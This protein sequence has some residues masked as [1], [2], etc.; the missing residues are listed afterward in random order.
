M[1]FN[2]TNAVVS[3][4]TT[5]QLTVA[6]PTGA[7]SGRVSVTAPSG[8]D[9]SDDDFIVPP[10]T[11]T[12]GQV[13][14]AARLSSPD[15]GLV[16]TVNATNKIA[17]ALFDGA[18]GQRLSL[19]FA[20]VSMSGIWRVYS[21]D[22]S[23]LTWSG[24]ATG[25]DDVDLGPLTQAGTYSLVLVPNNS[26]G[27]A[28]V[29]V[30]SDVL[31]NLQTD[32]TPLP[33]SLAAGQ[34]AMI[35]F[36][37][38]A[39]ETYNFVFTNYVST[40]EF[41]STAVTVLESDGTSL[42]SCGGFGGNFGL[43]LQYAGHRHLSLA[44][45]CRRHRCHVVRG[46]A[47]HRF[48]GNARAGLADR[49][50][51]GQGSAGTLGSSSA[52]ATGQ[53]V[54]RR[55]NLAN[56]VTAPLN[57]QVRITTYN[58]S[59]AEIDTYPSTTNLTRNFR[60]LAAGTYIARVAPT[61]NAAT[62]SFRIAFLAVQPTP[63]ASNGT[64]EFFSAQLVDQAGYFTFTGN[65]GQNLALG[66][67][68]VS[69]QSGSTGNVW[70]EIQKPDGSQ[71]T[72]QNCSPGVGRC[73]L[74]FRN[75]PASG[76]YR[77]NLEPSVPEKLNAYA[78]LSQS[79]TGTLIQD[80][81]FNIDLSSPGQNALLSFSLATAQTMVV[82]VGSMSLTPAGS[83]VSVRVFN[84]SNSQVA[85]VSSATT[86]AL[87]LPNLA[88]GNY[89]VTVD[90][91][92]A[93]TGTLQATLTQGT[94]LQTDGTAVNFAAV[95]PGEKGYF[96]FSA[97]AG[98]NIGVGMTNLTLAP[99]SPTTATVRVYRPDGTQLPSQSCSISNTGCAM[100]LRSLPSTGTYRIEVQAGASQT[101][102]FTIR[103]SHA[104]G[105][106]TPLTTTP[107]SAT[108]DV[109]GQFAIYTFEA[110]A[111][112]VAAVRLGPTTV[113]PVNSAVVVRVYNPSGAQVDTATV[114]TTPATL[115]IVNLVAGT[116]SVTITPTYAATG[117]AALTLAPGLTGSLPS[118]GTSSSKTGAVAGQFGYFTFTGT[119]GQNL[120]L[121]VTGL[122]LAPSSPTTVTLR[123]YKPDNSQL[124]S[125]SCSTANFGCPLALRALPA[126]GT[127]R[128]Q[129]EPGN[130]QTMAFVIMLSQSVTGTLA[131]GTPLPFAL[132]YPGQNA[133][134]TFT[135]TATQSVPLTLAVPSM[136]PVG[137][138]VSVRVYNAAGTQISTGSA[139]TAPLTLNLNSIAAGTYTVLVAPT[140]AATGNLQLS[141]P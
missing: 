139:T 57:Q 94:P 38:V 116:Y 43:C 136:T 56:I 73:Q 127:Y 118:D 33:M 99:N 32:G 25:I 70:I 107:L 109:P 131:A 92:T 37:A 100:V 64:T 60:A 47:E 93:A 140:F 80:V 14:M 113:S 36:D 115:N 5:T 111:G 42:K 81:P 83:S 23:L 35:R 53:A 19:V 3:A 75:L 122:A 9:A 71:L 44:S 103:L 89:T 91:T 86:A 63:L 124:T 130:Q 13:A 67:T 16:F 51:T 27:S 4:A 137:S 12:A 24:L 39:G 55:S 1:K 133:V 40:P 62:S 52:W 119:S 126:T 132:T 134:I 15:V 34:N 98:Q 10:S 46:P 11:Y 21:P 26:A 141:R 85:S 68:G 49:H 2:T 76:T 104:T 112:G 79:V 117:T 29:R 18:V 121:A 50:A 58:S 6:V 138:Q 128:V 123:V 82:N 31:A 110:T 17:V 41:T 22:G 120:G 54:A 77:V 74:S 135:T 125:V 87:V 78:T 20:N 30:V 69:Y 48:P 105:G 59:G 108:F 72:T 129:L 65:Q 84:A 66:L 45:Q 114:T 101:L 8:S 90:P 96:T 88:A 61:N 97:T 28:T 7:T 95:S 106:A 102:G